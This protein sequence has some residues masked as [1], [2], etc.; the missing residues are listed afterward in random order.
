MV[1]RVCHIFIIY[2]LNSKFNF[3]SLKK[4][5]TILINQ[6]LF[7]K[8]KAILLFLNNKFYF[9]LFGTLKNH[10]KYNK[11]RWNLLIY[12]F[13]RNE[14]KNLGGLYEWLFWS[15]DK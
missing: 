15:H 1:D 7:N 12:E 9:Q 14:F 8:S 3:R 4:Y 13:V 2:V 5:K 10:M 6:W 11:R